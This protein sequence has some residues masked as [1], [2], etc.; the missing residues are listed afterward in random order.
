M[1]KKI[2]ELVDNKTVEMFIRDNGIYM[3]SDYP[4]GRKRDVRIGTLIITEFGSGGRKDN[5][6][7]RFDDEYIYHIFQARSGQA[8]SHYRILDVK[9]KITNMY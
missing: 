4:I 5:W 2:K 6:I 7:V 3:E 8:T 9:E 1:L